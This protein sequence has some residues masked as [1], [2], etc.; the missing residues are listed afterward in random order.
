MSHYFRE[1]INGSVPTAP[2]QIAGVLVA[3]LVI[4]LVARR[5]CLLWGVGFVLA[6][7]LP[8]A[9]IPDRGGFAYLVPSVGW[10]VYAAG[11][12]ESLTSC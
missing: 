10:A 7:I 4:A 11:L 3:M 2:W 6:G 12:L 5:Q 8:L 9:F 1:L